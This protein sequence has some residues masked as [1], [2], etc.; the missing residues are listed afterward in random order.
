MDDLKAQR[1]WLKASGWLTLRSTPSDQQRR[2]PPPPLEQ[3][4]PADAELIDLPAA[5]GLELGQMSLREAIRRRE[6]EVRAGLPQEGREAVL[7]GEPEGFKAE[8]SSPQTDIRTAETQPIATDGVA[9]ALRKH[10]DAA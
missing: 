7:G 9:E 3:P 5:D 2:L 4:Y 10:T 1:E 6:N 8:D